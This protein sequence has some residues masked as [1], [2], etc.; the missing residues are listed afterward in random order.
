MGGDPSKS[1]DPSKI[2]KFENN[3]KRM[4]DFKGE[5]SK[6]RPKYT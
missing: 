2:W 4:T 3:N 1:G 5:V 6:Q